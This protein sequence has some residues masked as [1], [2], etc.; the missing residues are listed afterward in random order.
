MRKA[1][2]ALT[3]VLVAALAAPAAGAQAAP[4]APRLKAGV[5][6]ADITPQ[7]G[8]YLGGWTRADKTAQGQHTRL[9]SR[10]MVLER[11]GRKFALV[12][13]DLFMVP[14]G[15]V[16][17]IG[18]ILAKRGFSERNIL[19]SASHTHSGPGGYANFPTLNTAAP[20]LQTVNDPLSFARFLQPEKANPLLYSFLTR[21]IATAIRRADDDRAMATAGWGSSKIMGLTRNR[22]LEAHLANHG[23]IKNRGAGRESDDP[24]GYDHTIDPSVN[25]LRVDKVRRTKKRRLKRV[26]IGAWSTFADHG[27]VTKSSFEYYNADHHASA[28]RVFEQKVRTDAKVPAKQ[29]V[30]NVYGNSNEGDMSAGLGRDG[31]AASDYVGRV[32]ADAMYDAWRDAGRKSSRTPAFSSRWTRVC[33][34]GQVVEQGQ[35]VASES[36]VG[37][38]F[39]TGS[40]EERGPL[41]DI[42]GE[43]LEDRRGPDAGPPH[44][45]KASVPGVGAG[46]PNAVPLVAFRLGRRMIVS[47]PAEGTKEMGARIKSAVRSQI[48]GSG[49]GD[50]VLS[51]LA[52]EFILYL[53]T[54]QEYDR[55]HYEGGNTQFGRQSGNLLKREIAGLA[56]RLA[57]NQPAPAPYAFDPTNGIGPT[58]ADYGPG[59]A[60]AT[61]LSQP[62]PAY[63]RLQRAELSLAGRQAGARPAG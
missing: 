27:T 44:G 11:Q 3:L 36:Q 48:A 4:K 15:M 37:I 43:E 51:G 41:F 42:T 6:K 33:F 2:L 13:I 54:P 26:P 57:R 25:V 32:E 30:L 52:N 56:G 18:E 23:I 59:A 21:Q 34:C 12:Q 35:K 31:P 20:S 7:T 9:F 61:A 46:V 10:A 38:P 14:G 1:L 28:M 17:Q 53:T 58:A 60:S 16:K 8:Y 5:G 19:I 55:Q 24:G 47:L 63:A 50:V 62:R 45:V 22:S 40:E 29:E 49:I 39:L